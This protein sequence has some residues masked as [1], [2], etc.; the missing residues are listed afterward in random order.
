MAE[1]LTIMYIFHIRG[2]QALQQFICQ[3]ESNS[4]RP[5]K[6]FRKQPPFRVENIN[7]SPKCLLYRHEFPLMEL[8]TF[9]SFKA[10][11]LFF[12]LEHKL[13]KSLA[14]FA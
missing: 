5:F 6:V 10:I 13:M 3:Y 12:K 2:H 14:Q 9:P 1:I 11:I 4:Q 7:F 8:S